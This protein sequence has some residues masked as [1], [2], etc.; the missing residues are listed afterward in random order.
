MDASEESTVAVAAASAS[1]LRDE[2]RT[3]RYPDNQD[4]PRFVDKYFLKTK[5]IV[6][7]YGDCAV[8]Y[9][10]FMRRPVTCAP[11]LALRWLERI[12]AERGVE[13]EVDLRYREGAW[14]GAGEPIVLLTG[15]LFNLIDLETQF[16][17]K[18]GAACV[19]AYNAYVMCVELPKTGFL[20]MNAR[21]CAGTD[22]EE[23]MA[24]GASVGSRKAQ[25]KV[26]AKGFIGNAT[27]ETAHFFG[28]TRGYGTMPHALIG[29]A[30]ST[31]S[32]TEM[33]HA[34]HPDDDLTVLVDYFGR[35]ITDAL[36]VC[37]RFPELASA[38]R[39]SFRLDTHGGRFVEG[40]DTAQSYAILERKATRAIRGYRSS[41][42]L[43]YLIGTGV[44]A[45]AVWH[46]REALD[47]A[48]YRLAKIVGSSGF[49]PEKCRIMALADA[50]L[51]VVGTGSFLPGYWSETYATADII[52]YDGS[53]RVKVG[54][55]FLLRE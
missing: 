18:L 17:Q 35:E 14:V 33:F 38:G 32:A 31:V 16:L 55:E 49:T 22:M 46:L 26:G 51:D 15:S 44:S 4:L 40:L 8:T 52:D 54:R 19:A 23:L 29:Y 11:N 5:E 27:D 42:E 10:V 50:P 21:H 3:A 13:I 20:A 48:G 6:G 37:A 2:P 9:A 36:A 47:A 43:R 7:R 39:L 28:Q 24:Y 41:T 34:T 1:E 45:A 53:K 12:V 30:G 25:K